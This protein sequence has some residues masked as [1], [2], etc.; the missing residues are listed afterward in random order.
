MTFGNINEL[1]IYTFWLIKNILH[2]MLAMFP[3]HSFEHWRTRRT[4]NLSAEVLTAASLPQSV[5]LQF[6]SPLADTCIKPLHTRQ[7]LDTLLTGANAL[8]RSAHKTIFTASSQNC[9][10]LLQSKPTF[11]LSIQSS[12]DNSLQQR[13]IAFITAGQSCYKNAVFLKGLFSG[14]N[15]ISYIYL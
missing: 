12:M 9:I 4:K 10:C 1:G 7:N 6:P 15:A 2:L 5:L 8:S 14:E 3:V 13:K 11:I